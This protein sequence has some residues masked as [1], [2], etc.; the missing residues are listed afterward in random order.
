[1][2]RIDFSNDLITNSTRGSL[3]EV[4]NYFAGTGNET[5]GWFSMG[6][7][8]SKIERINYSNDLVAASIRQTNAPYVSLS[9][10]TT[11]ARSS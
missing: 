2:E 8:S 4:K 3:N 1:V 11:N 6:E 7:G 9:I 5:Y 10:G